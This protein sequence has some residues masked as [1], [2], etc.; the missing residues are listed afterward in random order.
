[1]ANATNAVTSN[2]PLN[3]NHKDFWGFPYEQNLSNPF[4]QYAFFLNGATI[5]IMMTFFVGIDRLIGVSMPTTYRQLNYALYFSVIGTITGALCAY[6][7]YLAWMHVY[8]PY[9]GEP[10][11][12]VIIDALGGEAQTFWFDLCITVNFLSVVIYTIVWIT[13]KFKTGT[14]DAMKKVF[15]SLLVMMCFVFFG[16]MMNAFVRSILLP[17]CGIPVSQWFYYS[18][19]FGLCANIASTSNIFILY[20]FSAEYRATFEKLLPFLARKKSGKFNSEPSKISP[21]PSKT[22]F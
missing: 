5:S 14:S 22:A 2:L 11:M 7:L 18:D 21:V 20:T 17:Y 19:Y 10:V 16:W 8:T 1:M 13:L 6:T 9:G 12:C 3:T 15:K 4:S